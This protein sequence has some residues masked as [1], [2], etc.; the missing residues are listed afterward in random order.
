M[1]RMW[2]LSCSIGAIAA[3]VMCWSACGGTVTESNGDDQQ[4]A[5]L[6]TKLDAHIDTVLD[7]YDSSRADAR[8]D[9]TTLDGSSPDNGF[10]EYHDPGCPDAAPIVDNECD[11]MAPKPG[12]CKGGMACYP[13]V[14]YP[15]PGD[16]CG[17][18]TYGA[19]CE[20]PGTATQGDPCGGVQEC[21]AGFVC[22]VSGAGDQ[23]VKL[24]SLDTPGACTNGMVCEPIDIPGYGGC[25]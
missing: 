1:L 18:E 13:Y 22:V 7:M 16:P 23:C 11:P 20:F 24:C 6:D 19:T 10:E 12:G 2:G 3:V 15:D 25:L 9:H 21:A 14:V 17:V 8:H 5:A 4:D